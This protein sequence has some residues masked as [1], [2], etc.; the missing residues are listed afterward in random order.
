MRVEVYIDSDLTTHS[1]ILDSISRRVVVRNLQNS[2]PA[3]SFQRK[4][5]IYYFNFFSP[6]LSISF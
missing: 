5:W 1:T 6:A 3:G 4:N 2:F